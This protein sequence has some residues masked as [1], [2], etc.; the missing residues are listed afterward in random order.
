[1][2]EG[3]RVVLRRELFLPVMKE[4]E[5]KEVV[6]ERRQTKEAESQLRRKSSSEPKFLPRFTKLHTHEKS[7]TEQEANTSTISKHPTS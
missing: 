2:L 4:F 5:E 1:M 6:T 7:I 3:D